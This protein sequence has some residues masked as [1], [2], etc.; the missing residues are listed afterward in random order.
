MMHPD[1]A[2]LLANDT[3]QNRIR[4]TRFLSRRAAKAAGFKGR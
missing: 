3:N 1:L 2:T 4:R